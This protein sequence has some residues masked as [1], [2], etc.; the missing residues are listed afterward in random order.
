MLATA[1]AH[2]SLGHRDEAISLLSQLDS[3]AA[4]SMLEKIRP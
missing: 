1:E 3:P 4:K 2:W